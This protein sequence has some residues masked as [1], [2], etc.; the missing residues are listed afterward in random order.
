MKTP[1]NMLWCISLC[2]LIIA[3]TEFQL[4]AQVHHSQANQI[5]IETESGTISW[6]FNVFYNENASGGQFIEVIKGRNSEENPPQDGICTYQF[7]VRKT[8][9]YKVW[10]RVIAPMQYENAFWVKMDEGD[11]IKWK[12]IEVGC[13]WH[14]DVVRDHERGDQEVTFDL[15]EGKHRISVA[16][17]LDGTRLDK[18][19]VVEDPKFIPSDIGPR[20]NAQF[21]V[22][23]SRPLVGNPVELD[24]S[25]SV[26]NY[27]KIS[28][29]LWNFGDGSA[30]GGVV[31]EHVF[32]HGGNY[33]VSLMVT[34]EKGN[35]GFR[36]KPI[37]VYTGKPIARFTHSPERPAP[38]AE[39]RFDASASI[40]VDGKIITYIWDFGDGENDH[41][42]QVIHRYAVEGKYAPSLTVVD[43][44]GN[45]DT[46][47]KPL[48]VVSPKPKKVIYET[49]MCLDVDDVGGLALLHALANRGEVELLAVCFNEVHPDGAAAIDA[50]NTWYGRGNI[51]VGVYKGKL[52]NPDYSAYLTPVSRFPHDLTAHNAPNAL[53]V[54]RQV[55]SK[56]PDHSVTI[57]SVGFMNNLNDLLNAEPEL[58]QRKVK[59]LVIMAGVHYDG[60][61]LVRHNLSSASK[62]I[63]EHWPTPVVISH[64][65]SSIKTGS[66]LQNA[67][68]ENPV[69]EAFYRFFNSSFCDRPSWDEMAVLYGVR[70]LSYYFEEISRGYGIL[71]DKFRWKMK[72]GFRTYLEPKLSNEEFEKIIEQLM[73]EPPRLE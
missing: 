24:A 55:L 28:R 39:V 12:G 20:V 72:K 54:Y 53:Q 15:S 25:Q 27:G 59:E 29:Y 8:G 65:G 48:M 69:R 5:W 32:S 30:A 10:G 41:G 31:A 18:L 14:W 57:I 4:R 58:I 47:A 3:I 40:D 13:Q 19:L 33:N 70:G 26:S 73:I 11:W 67:S 44:I 62:N 56:Q 51:P 1:R 7:T 63:L 35:S 50:I 2:I 60:F 38:E 43:D 9:S 36:K 37:I 71:N 68:P 52:E 42:I 45:R 34:D 16:Y 6:P 61:N 23:P 17:L 21:T 22:K 64:A 66:I 46:L 49:D